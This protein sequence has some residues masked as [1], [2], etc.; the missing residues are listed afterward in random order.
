MNHSPTYS[1]NLLIHDLSV[2]GIT[3][4]YLATRKYPVSNTDSLE[5]IFDFV[6]IYADNTLGRPIANLYVICHGTYMN[7][8][9]SERAVDPS[10][11]ERTVRSIACGGFRGGQSLKL[12]YDYLSIKNADVLNRV[13]GR[14]SRIIFYS[15]GV[16]GGNADDQEYKKDYN[17]RNKERK[18]IPVCDSYVDRPNYR[19]LAPTPGKQL[20]I[21]L[22]REAGC[23]VIGP[24][25]I[26][27]YSEKTY[28]PLYKTFRKKEIDFG[29]WEG[30]LYM[31][32]PE[33]RV[34]PIWR[35]GN[36]YF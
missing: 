32:T 18:P 5:E 6:K 20:I 4:T 36:D 33:G 17:R 9:V 28:D 15:C 7:T 29:E 34:M 19:L 22:S 3:P 21:T 23:P 1:Q 8:Y 35:A 14:V 26:Q 24:D 25:A 13:K 16:A 27:R 11:H 12:G 2:E 10:G 31:A 30:Q